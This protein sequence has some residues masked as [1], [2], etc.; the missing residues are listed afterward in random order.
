ML[1]DLFRRLKPLYGKKIDALWL[2][3]QLADVERKREIEGILTLLA[4]KRLGMTVGD[5][6]LVLDA[7]LAALIG[8]GEFTIGDVSYPGIAPYPFRVRR[9][10]LL[11]HVFILGPTGTGKSTLLLNLLVQVLAAG[12]PF[13]VF[14]FKRNYRTLLA[15]PAHDDLVVFTVGRQTAPLQLN[16]LQPPHG[17]E[18]E[19]WAEAL[20]DIISTSYLLM[21]GARNVLKEAL[22]QARTRNG[23]G[24][25]LAHAHALL[26][27]ELD[28]TK[29]G[30]RRYGWLESST[31]SLEELTKGSFGRALNANGGPAVSDL[32]T[33][34]VVFELQGFGDD[35]KRFFCLFFLQAILLLRKNASAPR[36][37]L[38]HVLVFDEGHNVFP[39]E[40]Q[41]EVSVPARLAREVREYGEAIIAATQQADVSESL[42]ANSGFKFIL[43]CDY[44][45]DVT[46]ASQL[47]QIKPEWLPKLAI[48]TGIARLP[49]RFYSPFLFTFGVQPI[50]NVTIPDA[51]VHEQWGRHFTATPEEASTPIPAIDEREATLLTDVAAVPISPITHRY[52][53]LRW[54]METGNRTKDAIIK[55]GLARF[56][57]V[58]TPKGQVKILTLTPAG[59][60][61]L[62]SRGVTIK[63]TRAGGAEHEFW[64][65]ELRTLLERHGYTVTEEYPLGGGRTADLRA[66]RE[67]H[68]RFVE[69]ETGRSDIPANIVKYQLGDDL[70]VFFT[71]ADVAQRYRDLV[72]LDRPGTRCLTPTEIDR[73]AA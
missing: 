31:R 53:R 58:S 26:H 28:G 73:V 55:R 50:K 10:E 23:E 36:E 18:F 24:A 51:V 35:Q 57:A 29:T 20:S 17:V 2:E 19:E 7:P 14:D 25:T 1:P 30:S 22:L 72:M 52:Q 5:E 44:P 11:R 63:T 21:Q 4:N 3:Y 67:G 71:S 15:A 69:V 59:R 6:K 64:K 8:S 56:D 45:R 42:I 32:L 66:E 61:L 37:T 40:R 47:L 34:P 13:M 38:Q 48:G 27:A 9:N 41:G 62:A 16:A 65:H 70:V 68:V 43:R 46:F 33:R 60:D 54:H 49:V 39:R 12:V